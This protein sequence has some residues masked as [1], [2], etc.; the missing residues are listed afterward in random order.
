MTTSKK[1]AYVW[2]WLPDC[3][4]PVP[5][6][7]IEIEE[8]GC[9]FFY[10]QSYLNN[11]N[12][13]AL[14]NFEVP[15]KGREKFYSEHE[16]H[17]VFCDSMPDAWGRRVLYHRFQVGAL[18]ELDMLLLSSSDRIGALHFQ[19]NPETFEPRYEN[20]ATLSQL[21]EAAS[22]VE[23]GE[24]LPVDLDVA[25][26]HGT[27]IGG[28]RPK[29]LINEDDNKYIAKFSSS[30][31]FFPVTKAEYL[32]MT[33]AKKC[34]IMV[35]KN[36]LIEVNNR[37]VLLVERFDREKRQGFF[38]RKFIASALNVLGLHES[39]AR[40]A[41]Y[42]DLANFIRKYCKNPD[43]DLPELY[44][45]I[46][47]NIL[48][49]NTDDHARNH[50]FFWDGEC[51]HLTPAY[52]ICPYSRVGRQATQAMIVGQMGSFSL[53]A[54]AVSAADF[55]GLTARQ[56]KNIADEMVEV[57]NNHWP[58]VCERSLLTTIQSKQLFQSAV[59]NPYVFYEAP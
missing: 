10:G 31:D 55:F 51:Y 36:K 5:A 7:K 59:L 27:S 40:Y 22:I 42:L 24:Q 39:E 56:A 44:R 37:Y 47:F 25:V 30:T 16:L 38:Q 4:E 52:D 2:V 3:E 46:V 26:M 9:S 48:I 20:A 35:A 58:E 19:D 18:S 53:I 29:A 49:G 15:L 23:R 33:L 1:G 57:I 34:G 14:S 11:K 8:S 13:M 43:I 54:N 6:G 17:R 50:A 21:M 45:R 12:A 41:S 28:A 32:A